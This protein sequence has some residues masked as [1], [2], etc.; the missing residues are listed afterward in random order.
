MD[1]VLDQVLDETMNDDNSMMNTSQVK[2]ADGKKKKKPEEFMK[3]ECRDLSHTL[4]KTI[5]MAYKDI[6]DNYDYNAKDELGNLLVETTDLTFVALVGLRDQI[7]RSLTDWLKV[8]DEKYQ[9]RVLCMTGD[10]K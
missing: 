7:D 1:E 8:L 4:L 5:V 6:P 10:S 3:N 9:I 2:G